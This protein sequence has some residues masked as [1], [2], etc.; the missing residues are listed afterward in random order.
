MVIR[1]NKIRA[2]FIPVLLSLFTE[3]QEVIYGSDRYEGARIVPEALAGRSVSLNF[4]LSLFNFTP[5]AEAA[6]QYAVSLLAPHLNSSQLVR[7]QAIYGLP[8]P[9]GTLGV[10]I[11]NS[12]MDFSVAAMDYTWYP[13]AL[14]NAISGYDHQST[15]LDLN[16]F[17][18]SADW[19]TG[20]DGNCPPNEYDLVSVVLHELIHGIGFIS[21]MSME[22]GM[23]K[24]GD[25]DSSNFQFTTFP[26]PD[27][28]HLPGIYDR[29]LHRNMDDL[30]DGSIYFNPSISLGQALRSDSIYF[31]GSA[32]DQLLG[33]Q[34]AKIYAPPVFR[35][36][37]SIHH[38]DEDAYPAGTS[39]SL[40]TPY[41]GLS[42]VNHSVDSLTLAILS[43][44][45]WGSPGLD[46]TEIAFSDVRVFPIPA[47][48]VLRIQ[49]HP[50]IL[51]Y[52]LTG[53][54]GYKLLHEE[55]TGSTYYVEIDV[56]ML[57]PGSY[58][59]LVE[60]IEGRFSKNIL[61]Y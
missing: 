2:L 13:A 41:I 31:S 49:S 39:Y 3:A 45:G 28:D 38:L 19:Y 36:G 29:H 20:T 47:D 4:D 6:F 40:M 10:C 26:M 23:G 9:G 22:G 16:I 52:R 24:Y 56:E 58:V 50:E 57:T 30:T 17:I 18:G 51:E 32:T 15:E 34:P 43:D 59:L 37:S 5:D 46:Q 1:W 35:D 55:L 42:E 21:L 7:I 8:L 12:D 25:P 53:I 60:T 11:P 54:N 33:G 61:I 14:S 44:I 27:F 48:R